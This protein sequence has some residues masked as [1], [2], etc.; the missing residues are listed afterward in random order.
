M[1][2]VVPSCFN[3]S[4]AFLQIKGSNYKRLAEFIFQPDPI[5]DYRV[6]CPCVSE[7]SMINSVTTLAPLFL[8]G[9]SSFCM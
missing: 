9:S 5:T 7:K 6:S 2:T 1:T 8:N 4:T 3:G